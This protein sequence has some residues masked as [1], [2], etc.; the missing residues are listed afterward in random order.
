M[1]S[2]FMITEGSQ[3][4]ASPITLF[5]LRPHSLHCQVETE[6]TSRIGILDTLLREKSLLYLHHGE[7]LERSFTFEFYRI[8]SK[9]A[10][11]A[12]QP[13]TS[14]HRKWLTMTKDQESFVTK[15][16]LAFDPVFRDVFCRLSDHCLTKFE[17]RARPHRQMVK[18]M[19]LLQD[20]I[21]ARDK[22][23]W[24]AVIPGRPRSISDQ[25][26]PVLW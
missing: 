10:L 21:E 5:I 25:P 9:D 1:T 7:I 14:D 2:P 3:A 20:E 17:M 26:L 4:Q 15:M 8:Q 16:R 18:K 11:I 12:F 13:N 24:T 6:R 19:L 22:P 23:S